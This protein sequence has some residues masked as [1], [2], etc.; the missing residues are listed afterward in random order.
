[1]KKSVISGDYKKYI[2]IYKLVTQLISTQSITTTKKILKYCKEDILDKEESWETY[3]LWR[4]LLLDSRPCYH[5]LSF[6][7]TIDY[8]LLL[9]FLVQYGCDITS[10]WDIV[11]DIE[12]DIYMWKYSTNVEAFK[13]VIHHVL[14]GIN[15][16]ENVLQRITHALIDRQQDILCD[17]AANNMDNEPL[18]DD[19]YVEEINL[20][21]ID[22]INACLSCL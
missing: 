14:K 7:T 10:L 20:G 1:M 3:T 9:F 16:D 13:K 8:T 11:S 17:W 19:S 15:N 4:K 22:Q 18:N 12:R 2:A 5:M 6:C 21:L